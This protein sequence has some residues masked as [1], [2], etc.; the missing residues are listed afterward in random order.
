M[1]LS[2]F[3]LARIADD[4]AWLGAEAFYLDSCQ[5]CAFGQ[6]PHSPYSRARLAADCEAKR[7]IAGLHQPHVPDWSSDPP[8]CESCTNWD[9]YPFVVQHKGEGWPCLTFRILAAP[10]ADH[11]DYDE[12]W[13]P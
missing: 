12:A 5:E 6:Q 1:D 11:P 4:E 9:D 13:R 7:R 3:L 8:G 2:Q 10:Y